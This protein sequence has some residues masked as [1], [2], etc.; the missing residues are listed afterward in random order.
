M[1]WWGSLAGI[2]KAVNNYARVD[3]CV[4]HDG[5][6]AIPC[7]RS[8]RPLLSATL[9]NLKSMK[10][11]RPIKIKTGFPYGRSPVLPSHTETGHATNVACPGKNPNSP[12]MWCAGLICSFSASRLVTGR[13]SRCRRAMLSCPS[14]ITTR[15]ASSPTA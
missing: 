5:P 11:G 12:Y 9:N 7:L 14:P 6:G 8:S 2:G 15:S 10:H 4:N 13:A 3:E 1:P